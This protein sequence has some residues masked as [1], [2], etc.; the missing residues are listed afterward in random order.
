MVTGISRFE[1]RLTASINNCFTRPGPFIFQ[2]N[3]FCRSDIRDPT[4]HCLLIHYF[5]QIKLLRLQMGVINIPE[6]SGKS[7]SAARR[8]PC[9]F[10]SL[11][12]NASQAWGKTPSIHTWQLGLVSSRLLHRWI[13]EPPL[14]MQFPTVCRPRP[15]FPVAEEFSLPQSSP[16]V[17]CSLDLHGALEMDAAAGILEQLHQ[18]TFSSEIF[19][20]TLKSCNVSPEDKMELLNSPL[21]TVFSVHLLQ[22]NILC[23][24]E[25]ILITSFCSSQGSPT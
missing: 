14:K 15:V 13:L 24:H 10:S 11:S 3:G 2:W 18:R 16:D 12:W 6:E 25:E 20:V 5:P 8:L 19:S 22:V 21:Q 1:T 7:F 23:V 17:C 4:Q 9:P